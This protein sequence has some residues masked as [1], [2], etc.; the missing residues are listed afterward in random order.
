MLPT[1]ILTIT[2]LFFLCGVGFSQDDTAPHKFEV[3]AV[4]AST[5]NATGP[6]FDILPSGAV[7]LNTTMK[8]IVLIAYKLK[9]YQLIGAPKW[10]DSE[11]YRIVAKP[12]AGP[13]PAEQGKQQE[14]TSERLRFLLEERFQF[15]AH[16]EMRTMQQYALVIAKGGPKLKE[17]QR[18]A[19]NFRLSMPKGKIATRG[20]AKVAML[21]SVLE[22]IVGY[23]VKDESGLTGYYD[24]QL[25]YA[26]DDKPDA[27]PSV[28]LALQDQLGLKLESRKGPVD[29]LVIDR[30]ERPTEN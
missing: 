10:L 9:D 26:P 30:V 11:Y 24:I 14:L 29:V 7:N 20:G 6:P 21:T 22:G 17:I 23:P 28:F 18:D 8:S 1:R 25:N 5:A 15:A 27:G 19:A 2:A 16:H 3:A 12:P 4:K 13:I